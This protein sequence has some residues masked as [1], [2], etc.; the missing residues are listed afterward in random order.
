MI[1]RTLRGTT[2]YRPGPA[3]V[4][5]GAEVVAVTDRSDDVRFSVP[6][7]TQAEAARYLD[8]ASSTF[9]N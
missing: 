6:L 9:R 4:R 7:Y 3:T 1:G 2:V 5:L 8:M